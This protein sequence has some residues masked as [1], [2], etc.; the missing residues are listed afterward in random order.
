MASDVQ[1]RVNVDGAASAA[2]DLSDIDVALNRLG[3]AADKSAAAFGTLAQSTKLGQL[4]RIQDIFEN[5]GIRINAASREVD[6]LAS[7]MQAVGRNNAFRQLA[8]ELS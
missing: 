4:A 6:E 5:T 8:E 1:I 7:R 2:H 3:A